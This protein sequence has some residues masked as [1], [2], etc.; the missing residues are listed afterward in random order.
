M[1]WDERGTARVANIALIDASLISTSNAR[2]FININVRYIV[3]YIITYCANSGSVSGFGLQRLG[4]TD[5]I[6]RLFTRNHGNQFD[7]SPWRQRDEFSETLRH[8]RRKNDKSAFLRCAY[9]EIKIDATNL[10]DKFPSSFAENSTNKIKER[11]SSSYF[12]MRMRTMLKLRCAPTLNRVQ[13]EIQLD[14]RGGESV[15]GAAL[16]GAGAVAAL[17][18]VAWRG[19]RGGVPIKPGGRKMR[20]VAITVIKMLA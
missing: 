1:D 5:P 18:P 17:A 16:W 8:K 7:P 2:L 14:E 12:Y 9:T 6:K 19:V 10:I 15:R 13:G 3:R 20:R 4:K 11:K